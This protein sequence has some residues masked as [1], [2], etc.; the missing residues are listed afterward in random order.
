[1]L[2]KVRDVL[3]IPIG[4]ITTLG[5]FKRQEGI[6]LF[7]DAGLFAFLHAKGFICEHDNGEVGKP[8]PSIY[9]FAAQQVGVP[10]DRCLFIGENLVE[11][12]AAIAAGMK[13]L[14]KPCPPGRDVQ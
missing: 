1:M 7:Q 12:T 6:K 14:L 4:I 13:G 11:V 3:R 5:S 2:T 9:H 10:I 8:S